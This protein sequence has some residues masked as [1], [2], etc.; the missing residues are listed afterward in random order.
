MAPQHELYTQFRTHTFGPDQPIDMTGREMDHAVFDGKVTFPLDDELDLIAV[1][2]YRRAARVHQGHA[3]DLP[4]VAGLEQ[5]F[6][7][8]DPKGNFSQKDMAFTQ[9]MDRLRTASQLCPPEHRAVLADLLAR[10]DKPKA[11][12]SLGSLYTDMK[13][14]CKLLRDSHLAA[15]LCTDPTVAG[16]IEDTADLEFGHSQNVL[17]FGAMLTA[18]EK[19]AGLDPE[20]LTDDDRE[21]MDYH[22][23]GK[24][25]RLPQTAPTGKDVPH[26]LP[27]SLDIPFPD[28]RNVVQQIAY[29]HPLNW[30]KTQAEM[31]KEPVDNPHLDTVISRYVVGTV[32]KT[33]DTVYGRLE[34]EKPN[35]YAPEYAN[36]A[37]MTIIDGMTVE[38]H[39][40]REYKQLQSQGLVQGGFASWYDANMSTKAHELVAAALV[41]GKQVEVFVPDADGKLPER[42]MKLTRSGF[43]IA[44]EN[45]ALNGFQRFLNKFGFFKE[46]AAKAQAME[47]ARERV[48]ARYLT[49]QITKLSPYAPYVTDPF[50]G[51]WSRENGDIQVDQAPNRDPSFRTQ[52]SGHTT[53][54]VCLLAAQGH[55]LKDILDPNKLQAEKADAG[56]LYMQK[57]TEVGDT[58]DQTQQLREQDR[59]WLGSV[60][61]RGAQ[62][63]VYQADALIQSVDLRDPQQ[64]DQVAPMLGSI[65]TMFKDIEQESDF[66]KFPSTKAG[67]MMAMHQQAQAQGLDATVGDRWSDSLIERVSNI[68][69]FCRTVAGT[70]KDRSTIFGPDMDET[71]LV[72]AM[73]M[74]FAAKS[75][76]D[77]YYR[78]PRAQVWDQVTFMAHANAVNQQLRTP[79]VSIQNYLIEKPQ[80]WQTY[81]KTAIRGQLTELVDFELLDHAPMVADRHRLTFPNGVP[82]VVQDHVAAPPIND[83]VS[84]AFNTDKIVQFADTQTLP[85]AMIH[86]QQF[87]QAEQARVQTMRALQM[88]KQVKDSF[89]ATVFP[90]IDPHAFPDHSNI[91]IRTKRE[92]PVNYCIARLA[93]RFQIEDILDPNKLRAEKMEIGREYLG[94]VRDPQ[95]QK[96]NY[97]RGL[98]SGTTALKQQLS[99]RLQ[100]LDFTNEDQL[101]KVLPVMSNASHALFDLSQEIGLRT[102]TRSYEE[103]TPGFDRTSYMR[104]LKRVSDVFE[105]VRKG[106]DA[107]SA[108]YEDP[109]NRN[110]LVNISTVLR[111]KF[112]RDDLVTKMRRDKTPWESGTFNADHYSGIE[113]SLVETPLMKDL[114]Q[115]LTADQ[116]LYK[117]L[118]TDAICGKLHQKIVLSNKY[119]DPQFPDVYEPVIEKAPGYDARQVYDMGQ[120]GSFK[121]TFQALVPP[122]NQPVR[123]RGK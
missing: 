65:A 39:M 71:G 24:H 76:I 3:A 60:Y 90:G 79:I 28:F 59:R 11:E 99:Q 47:D 1:E 41:Q 107:A 98:I 44:K 89:Q 108:L 35:G 63:M 120:R 54:C 23:M 119:K 38:E 75:M 9:R 72:S 31:P 96:P 57:A 20:P 115:R 88:T 101:R 36:R 40:R 116:D 111:S 92:A 100:K 68:G 113:A 10:I 34:Q 22:L 84:I 51:A 12:D 56:R 70:V 49:H 16:M 7:G 87:V 83:R 66:D 33:L 78:A 30:D 73:T 42:P 43:Q 17:R 45:Y 53:A 64:L 94:I 26:S 85:R 62:A 61:A 81:A 13:K 2:A 123:A 105:T 67:F 117:E 82:T 97:L 77:A 95:N 52:R 74:P 6:P 118:A 86:S 122:P 106:F 14:D 27:A 69:V 4:D 50:F 112:M 93:E 102:N 91:G 29:A 8:V 18:M 25:P 80:N 5:L 103:L 55:S 19:V 109:F 48:R 32:K 110:S 21:L 58:P 46:K 37:N 121:A 15:R 114:G 104:G